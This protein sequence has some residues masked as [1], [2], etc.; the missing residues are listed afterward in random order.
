MAASGDTS[1]FR[2]RRSSYLSRPFAN[3]LRDGR[4][5]IMYQHSQHKG[6]ATMRG[7]VVAASVG[8]ALAI[9]VASDVS[10]SP[11]IGAHHCISTHHKR[12]IFSLRR[13]SS[14]FGINPSTAVSSSASHVEAATSAYEDDGSARCVSIR[15]GA[16]GHDW[17]SYTDYSTVGIIN[18]LPLDDNEV[19]ASLARHLEDELLP[20]S[21]LSHAV[22]GTGSKIFGLPRDEGI[23]VLVGTFSHVSDDGACERMAPYETVGTLCD[24][25]FLLLDGSEEGRFGEIDKIAS[26]L[27][28]IKR[29]LGGVPTGLRPRLV[30]YL[31]HHLDDDDNPQQYVTALLRSALARVSNKSGTDEFWPSIAELQRFADI[32]IIPYSQTTLSEAVAAGKVFAS[33]SEKYQPKDLSFSSFQMLARQVYHALLPNSDNADEIEFESLDASISANRDIVEAINSEQSEA[34]YEEQIDGEA[35]DFVDVPSY[36]DDD[37]VQEKEIMYSENPY[38]DTPVDEATNGFVPD[39]I[40][41][42]LT[43]A[44][45]RIMQ[46]CEEKMGDLE[47]KQDEFLL[48]SEEG[49]PILEFGS[50]AQAIITYAIES[51]DEIVQGATLGTAVDDAIDKQIN[52][53]KI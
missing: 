15:G 24:T 21:S 17:D 53:K 48:N 42:Q 29:R 11:R 27:N 52:G 7:L 33:Q 50:D 32:A 41:T 30:F 13:R 2:C 5:E 31:R 26:F 49:M 40:F 4:T 43:A 14:L 20:S 10:P 28:G 25:T 47:A 51:F 3:P 46:T 45:R 36:N 18:L 12:S 23:S 35:T 39:M 16:G 1:V 8:A 34:D 19:G 22:I 38:D 37:D 44:S 9:P 6:I